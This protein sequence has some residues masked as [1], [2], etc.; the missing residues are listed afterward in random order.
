MKIYAVEN[1]LDNLLLVDD[2]LR[3]INGCFT[4]K[5]LNDGSLEIPGTGRKAYYVMEAPTPAEEK[6]VYYYHTVFEAVDK[7]LSQPGLFDHCV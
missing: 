3:V 2:K 7:I 6:G 1:D 4:C 5:K